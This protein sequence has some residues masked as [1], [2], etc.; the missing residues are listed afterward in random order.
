MKSRRHRPLELLDDGV[1]SI[2]PLTKKNGTVLHR[3]RVYG[4]SKREAYNACKLLEKR[5]IPCMELR[6]PQTMEMAALQ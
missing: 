4:L 3:A 6:G 2:V 5:R 1:V